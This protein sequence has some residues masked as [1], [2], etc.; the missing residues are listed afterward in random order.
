MEYDEIEP[1]PEDQFTP[2]LLL[3]KGEKQENMKLCEIASPTTGRRFG[4]C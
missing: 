2:T 1:S 3:T 4:F